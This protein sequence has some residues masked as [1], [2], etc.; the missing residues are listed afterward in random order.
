MTLTTEPRTPERAPSRRSTRAD[1][2]PTTTGTRV[3]WMIKLVLIALLDAVGGFAVFT[4]FTLDQVIPAAA[5]LVVVVALNVVYLKKGLLPAKYLAP[6][7]IFLVVFQIFVVFY[8]GYIAFTNYGDQHNGS[9]QDAIEQIIRTAQTRVEDSAQYRVEIYTQGDQLGML[10]ADPDGTTEFGTADTPLAPAGAAPAGW[11]KLTLQQILAQQD[12]VLA[13]TVPFDDDPNSGTLRTAD[14]STAFV[15]TSALQYDETADT[16][17]RTDTG[18]VY[19]DDGEGTFRNADGQQLTPGWQVPVGF[20]NFAQ[21]FTNDQLRDP[22]LRVIVWTFAFAFLSVATTFA[23]GLFLAIVFNHPRVRGK[24]I[25]RAVLILPYAFPAFL[26]GLVWAGMLNPEFGFFNQVLFGGAQIPWLS[27]PWL[28][29]FSV[30]LVNLWLGFPYMFLVCTGA[31]QSLP[32]DVLE[33]ATMDGAG[34]WRIFRAIKLPLLLVSVAPLLIASFAFNFNNFNVVYMLTRGWPR[35]TDTTLDIG[36]TDLLITLVYKVAFGG[37]G[38]RDYGLASAF[39][40]L[41][42]LIVTVVTIISFRRTR[43]L[44]DINS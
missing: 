25:Y 43:A 30:L 13:L 8:T 20:D 12:E 6:G 7:L 1:A 44:E 4:L 14:G 5:V 41:I 9:K 32:D 15:Y 28:A 21:A 17:T 10:V 24:K 34:A 18:T 42:F 38:G 2:V 19:T 37:G 36:A 27:D 39:A 26:S 11:T 40:I 3:A 35:F 31:L 22:L 29:R 23:L 33:A 16:F